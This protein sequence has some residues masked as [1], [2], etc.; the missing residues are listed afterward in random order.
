M[1]P[2]QV[3]DLVSHHL[4]PKT[5][6]IA[7]CVCKSWFCCISSDHIWQPICTTHYPSL[8]NLKLTNPALPYYRLYAMA[9]AAA[10]RRF[11]SPS[12][13][14]LALHELIFTVNIINGNNV[15]LCL[16][17]PGNELVV[18][19]NGVFKFDI[20]VPDYEFEDAAFES[21]RVTWSV[22]LKG[23]KG[24][25]NM[26]ECQGKRGIVDW[27]FWAELPLPGCCSSL[28]DSGV[29][30]DMR[31]EFT[32]SKRGRNNFDVGRINKV[33]VGMLSSAKLRYVGVD[34][35]LRYL[36]HFL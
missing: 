25:F 15:V 17:K 11:E 12:K 14:S 20:D 28:V 7:S 22:V 32:D 6:A 30:A 19:C 18:D 31:L 2:W 35:G 36:Q 8:S 13:P 3:F 21:V 4:D 10:K 1:S 9:S 24:V 34:D 26:L 5:L 33:T 23:W 16:Q 29:V 27:W